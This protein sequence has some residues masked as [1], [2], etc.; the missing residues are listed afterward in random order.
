MSNKPKLIFIASSTFSMIKGPRAP[1]RLIKRCL[2]IV[3]IWSSRIAESVSSPL[4]REGW[5]ITSTGYGTGET[6]EVIAATIVKG[7]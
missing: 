5:T 3:R 7:L 2:S 1:K 4:V 6:L